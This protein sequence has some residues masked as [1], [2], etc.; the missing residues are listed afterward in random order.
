MAELGDIVFDCKH[1]ASLA[2]FWADVFDGY[3]VAPYDEEE[4]ARL[5]DLGIDDPEDDPGVLVVPSAPGLP[6]MYFQQ[7]PESK[8]V[9]NRVHLDVRAP[10][11]QAEADRLVSIGATTI[12]DFPD[13]IVLQDPEG[14]EFCVVK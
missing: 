12:A 6:R 1:P 14:N 7:V 11:A 10:D 3:A 5:R 2:R 8:V 13:W 9:K 4:L